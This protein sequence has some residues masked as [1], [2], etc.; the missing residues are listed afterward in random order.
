MDPGTSLVERLVLLA[1]QRASDSAPS[2]STGR[3]IDFIAR[4]SGIKH[5]EV[6]RVLSR[7]EASSAPVVRRVLDDDGTELWQLVDSDLEQP[8]VAAEAVT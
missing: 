6:A 5:H 7:L 1:A 4:R 2:G 3:T 8:T